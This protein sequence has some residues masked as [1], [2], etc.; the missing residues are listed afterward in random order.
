[1]SKHLPTKSG[2]MDGDAI[3]YHELEKLFV[4]EWKKAGAVKEPV[5]KVKKTNLKK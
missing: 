1:M 2:F 3:D 5:P 4:K